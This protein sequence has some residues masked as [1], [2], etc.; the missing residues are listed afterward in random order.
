MVKKLLKENKKYFISMIESSI[1]EDINSYIPPRESHTIRQKGEKDDTKLI[2]S[3]T[4]VSTKIGKYSYLTP[5]TIL[6]KIKLP[7]TCSQKN[8]RYIYYYGSY[9]Y[10]NNENIRFNLD[11]TLDN[12]KL[13]EKIIDILEENNISKRI[14]RSDYSS[15]YP[16]KYEIEYELPI[17]GNTITRYQKKQRKTLRFRNKNYNVNMLYIINSYDPFTFNPYGNFKFADKSLNRIYGSVKIKYCKGYR[18]RDIVCMI[19]PKYNYSSNWYLDFKKKDIYEYA[20]VDLGENMEITHIGTMGLRHNVTYFPNCFE[21]KEYGLPSYPK[22]TI[23][24][25]NEK[26]WVTSYTVFVRVNSGKKWI[27]LGKYTGNK[28]RLT[29]VVHKFDQK[30]I[31]RYVRVIPKTYSKFPGFQ[32]SL[33]G[34][35]SSKNK[36]EDTDTTIIYTVKYPSKR[37]YKLYGFGYKTYNWSKYKINRKNK[38]K[39]KENVK[40]FNKGLIIENNVDI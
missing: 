2:I 31:A 22:I 19:N 28:D 17:I 12:N 25:D 40:K 8:R 20:E 34:P 18:Y 32:I 13:W 7:Y 37:K 30:V 24:T 9:D 36:N 29:E 4:K 15:N 10:Y 5:V 38:M 26:I 39:L 11:L 35:N 16:D 1:P 6:D 27:G 21:E 33:F 23:A 3:S 14:K